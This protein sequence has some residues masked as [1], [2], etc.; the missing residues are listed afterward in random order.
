L[1]K[2]KNI[3]SGIDRR[4]Q[5]GLNLRTLAGNGN[6]KVIRRQEDQ[7]RIFFVDRYSP[8]LFV[9]I[10]GILFLCVTDALFT[11]HLLNYGAYET[12]PVMAFLLNTGPYAFFIS[13]YVLTLISTFALF[14]FRNVII[15]KINIS[16]HSLLY[17]MAWIYATVVGWEL[18]LIFYVN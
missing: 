3:R 10:V 1:A 7:D 12:N 9:T 13:K 14:M 15:R 2:D 5:A 11:L 18:Y 17:L 8:V 16:T 4:K 6:R